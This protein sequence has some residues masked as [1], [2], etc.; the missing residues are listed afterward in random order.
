MSRPSTGSPSV[1]RPVGTVL[2]LVLLVVLASSGAVAV[3]TA[4]GGS[5]A[6]ALVSPESAHPT[7]EPRS[8]IDPALENATGE[9]RVVV[10]FEDLESD[11]IPA[12]EDAIEHR[13]SHANESQESLERYADETAGVTFERGF[14][15][16][17]AAVVT[18]D[19]DS[20]DV[21]ELARVDAVTGVHA[22]NAVVASSGAADGAT[23]AA[24]D[25]SGVEYADGLET[26]N[27]PQAWEEFDTRG[28]GATVVVLDSGVDADH[29]D[30]EV[31]GWK[32][33]SDAAA[34]DPIDYDGHG[35]HVSGIVAGGDESGTQIGVAPEAE[36]VHGAIV[37]DCENE[38]RG[39]ESTV[40]EG[41]EWAIEQDADV[42]SMSFGWKGYRPSMIRAVENAN[43]AG[44]VV[45]AGS[46]NE[47]EGTS[48]SPGNVYDAV[49]VGA[50]TGSDSIVDFSSG[51]EIATDD[52]WDRHAPD[53]WPASY[54]VP[55]VVAPGVGVKGPVP[56]GD[57]ASRSGT[58]KATPHVAGTVALMQSATEDDLTPDEIQRALRETAWK[59][60]DEPDDPDTR[61]G[62]GIIDTREA[63]D[64]VGDHSSVE[65]TVTD[66]VTDEPLAEATVEIVAEDGTV[67]EIETDEDGTFDRFGLEG[68]E[69]YTVVVAKEGY[70]TTAETA[71]VPADERVTIDVVA[72]GDGELEVT[73]RDAHFDAG[74]ED[75]S[76]A[77]NGSRG[78]YPGNHLE[79]GTYVVSDVPT[80]EYYTLETNADGYGDET[81]RIAVEDDAATRTVAMTGDAT[82]AVTVESE[83]ADDP[84]ENASVVLERGDGESYE[85][86]NLTDETGQLTITL[87]GTGESYTVE[88]TAPEFVTT[89]VE[90]DPVESEATEAVT[91]VLSEP[92]LPVPGFGP[93]VAVVALLAFALLATRI[94]RRA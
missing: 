12:S 32:D 78:V 90:S 89:A 30:L 88:A 92:L 54:V 28:E 76:A 71:F 85:T 66:A 2:V 6:S 87:P 40:L 38:C 41:V 73:V 8:A 11:T 5:S 45:V 62:H 20:A 3:G 7:E 81:R 57:Y 37:T 24:S 58:S 52:A 63:I 75:A 79:N 4:D 1:W 70:E 16:T 27:V 42:V 26:I 53:D 23:A 80:D 19:S 9:V 65:G 93:A 49:A 61:Y 82:L 47:G 84:I 17:N 35:T 13:Q 51:E 43:D 33:F 69:E 50:S 94:D 72:A 18:V 64:A 14:W 91:V 56:G 21:R 29:P 44:A 60:D 74:I 77:L 83:E 68:D 48:I 22:D 59:P 25:E 31:D 10:Q 55:D 67:A 46:G 36:L 86:A 39:R 34:A 15:I